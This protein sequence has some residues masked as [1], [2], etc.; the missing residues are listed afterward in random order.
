MGQCVSLFSRCN[1]YRD[2]KDGSDEECGIVDGGYKRQ[3]RQ[4]EEDDGSNYYYPRRDMRS[5]GT[6]VGFVCL[7]VCLSVCYSTF[8]F[9]NVCSSHKRYD[10]LN[11]Q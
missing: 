2:C 1:G 8:H 10:L 7:S 11:G 9:S 6:V 5:E 4:T 3:R